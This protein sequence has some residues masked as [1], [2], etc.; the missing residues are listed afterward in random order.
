MTQVATRRRLGYDCEQVPQ[1]QTAGSQGEIE[2][3]REGWREGWQPRQ[4]LLPSAHFLRQNWKR[5]DGMQ[6]C[7][8]LAAS[9]ASVASGIADGARTTRGSAWLDRACIINRATTTTTTTTSRRKRS[10]ANMQLALAF[11]LHLLPNTV[12]TAAETPAEA[13]AVVAETPNVPQS[14]TFSHNQ[15]ASCKTASNAIKFKT[16][17]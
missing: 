14:V 7:Q 9:V 10:M 15:S 3:E 5:L 6:K 8:R 12:K 1:Q 17:L 4:A 11:L 13:A 16:L 2:G